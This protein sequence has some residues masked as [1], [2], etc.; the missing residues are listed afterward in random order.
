MRRLVS[1]LLFVVGIFLISSCERRDISEEPYST[2][3]IKVNW[4]KE[5]IKTDFFYVIA[6]PKDSTKQIIRDFIPTYGGTIQVPTGEYD[7]LIF[8]YDYE[9]I[10]VNT[11]N[12]LYKSYSTTNAKK[13]NDYKD[14]ALMDYPIFGQPDDLFYVGKYE[15]IS[16]TKEK[17]TYIAE[18][19]PINTIKKYTIKIKA[20][21][22][23]SLSSGYAIVSGFAGRYLMGRQKIDNLAVGVFSDIEFNEKWITLSFNTWGQYENATHDINFSFTLTNGEVQTEV[24]NI[25]NKIRGLPNG[26]EITLD[27]QSVVFKEVGSSGGIGGEVVGWDD[28]ENVNIDL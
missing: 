9:S 5:K 16:A 15:N 28:E 25:D 24:F 4:Q 27:G 23:S 12:S 22:T 18:I 20:Y 26:G 2:I 19:N 14:F 13:K 6:Y 1:C 7:I 10:I 21:N 11:S 3:N 17:T 8:S